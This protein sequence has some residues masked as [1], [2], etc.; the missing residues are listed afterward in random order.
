MFF[1][2]TQSRYVA[3]VSD[4]I[5]V[6]RHLIQA[7]FSAPPKKKTHGEKLKNS[8]TQGKKLKLKRKTPLFGIFVEKI[9]KNWRK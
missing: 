8:E 2:N 9:L 5:P 6:P 7:F 1:T 4:N 3:V